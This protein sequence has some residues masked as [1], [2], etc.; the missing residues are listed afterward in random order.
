MRVV[1]K[2][3]GVVTEHDLPVKGF[4]VVVHEQGI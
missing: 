4:M 2:A 1:S 3:D